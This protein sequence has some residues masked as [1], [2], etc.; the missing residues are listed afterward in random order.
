MLKTKYLWALALAALCAG[1]VSGPAM[2]QMWNVAASDLPSIVAWETTASASVEA[3]NTGSTVWDGYDLRSVE[4]TTDTVLVPVDRWGLTIVPSAGPTIGPGGSELYEFDVE[5][6]CLS[7]TFQ[8]AWVLTDGGAAIPDDLASAD[9]IVVRYPDEPAWAAQYI[10]DCAGAVPY[11]VQGYP[12]GLYRPNIEVNRDAMAVFISR[13]MAL[14]LTCPGTATFPDVPTDFWAYCYIETLANAG[15]VA[16][17]PSGDYMPTY[18]VSR[19]QMAVFIARGMGLDLTTPA[20]ATFPDVPTDFWAYSEIESCVVAGVVAGYGDGL[21][22]PATIV[23]R[24]QMAVYSDR[25][26]IIGMDKPIV[27]GGPAT[28]DGV[29]AGMADGVNQPGSLAYYG[30]SNVNN[31]PL[32]PYVAFDASSLTPALADAGAWAVEFRY[33]DV[34]IPTAPVDVA[35]RFFLLSAGD[36]NAAI[37]AGAS[38]GDP[39]VLVDEATLAGLPDG[40]YSMAMSVLVGD[41][42]GN[43]IPCARVHNFSYVQMEPPPPGAPREPDLFNDGIGAQAEFGGWQMNDQQQASGS[44]AFLRDADNVY[45]STQTQTG[46]PPWCDGDAIV[47]TWEGVTIPGGATEMVVELEY[48]IIANDGTASDCCGDASWSNGNC[49]GTWGVNDEP[50]DPGDDPGDPDWY[51]HPFWDAE[52]NIAGYDS[53]HPFGWGNWMADW[54]GG[55][56]PTDWWGDYNP[57]DDYMSPDPADVHGGGD[58]P[59]AEGGFFGHPLSPSCPTATIPPGVFA[60]GETHYTW[61]ADAAT[62]ADYI[63]GDG[64]VTIIFCGGSTD[65]FWVDQ[66]TLGFTVPAP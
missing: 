52:T 24:A 6:P 55:V 2:A 16:G 59:R 19:A 44:L 15:V 4:G 27:V 38:T 43:A 63:S 12:D 34:T 56:W 65:Q 45:F 7:G 36:I 32:Y 10:E 8:N 49:C 39:L 60:A 37:A 20:T 35:S 50:P 26:F 1:M 11:I 30:W 23:D 18:A 61:T 46:T 64:E 47:F 31:D 25:A 3:E 40:T 28:T 29:L 53:A 42:D 54:A 33:Q 14:S 66:L 9:T 48:Y 62:M 22:R 51:D 41:V 21:Y 13:G 17:Y 57:G 58:T 5:G